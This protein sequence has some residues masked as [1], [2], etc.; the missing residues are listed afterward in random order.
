MTL[1]GKRKLFDKVL[2]Q[3]IPIK[4][5]KQEWKKMVQP[6]DT[7]YFDKHIHQEELE[8][9]FITYLLEDYGIDLDN[10]LYE[11]NDKVKQVMKKE[12]V[13]PDIRMLLNQI[14][15]SA[16]INYATNQYH[17][18]EIGRLIEERTFYKQAS[19]ILGGLTVAMFIT[20][21]LGL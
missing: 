1:Y 4:E 20:I 7:E 3:E 5:L 14:L 13:P 19:Y 18:R 2:K 17:I 11:W 15:A 16:R 8:K 9:E 21:L 12:E 6:E 10:P